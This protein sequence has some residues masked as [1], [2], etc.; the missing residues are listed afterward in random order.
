MKKNAY[1]I[2]ITIATLLSVMSAQC[3]KAE[4]FEIKGFHIDLRVEVMTMPALKAFATQLHE[5]GVNTI[6]MEYE[7]TYPYEKHFTI[8]SKYAYT[9]DEIRDF[10]KHCTTLGIDVIPLQQTF[11]HT[12]YILRHPR[13]SSLAEKISDP[14]QICPLKTER[15]IE[16]FDEL[17]ADMISLH[18]SRYFHIG[19]DETRLLGACPNCAEKVAK[20]GKSKLFAD[21]MKEICNTVIRHGKIPI[22]WAD[23]ILEHPEYISELPKETIFVDWNYGWSNR[24]FG[25]AEALVK[26]GVKFWGAPAIRSHPDNMHITSWEKHF[27]NQKIFIPYC[28]EQKYNGIVMTSWSTSG[29]SSPIW[30][31][32]HEVIDM[33]PLRYVYPM[34]GFN[35]LIYM[36]GKALNQPEPIDPRAVIAEYA[37]EQLG[38]SAEEGKTLYEILTIPQVRFPQAKPRADHF[39]NTKSYDKLIEEMEISVAK[40]NEMKPSRNKTDLEH[41]IL[42][43]NIRLNYI[44][45]KQVEAEINRSEIAKSD[46]KETLTQLEKIIKTEKR[47]CKKF[48]SLQRGY[49]H[50]S[51][52]EEINRYRTAKVIDTYDRLTKAIS[53]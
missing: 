48:A 19:G 51:E 15:C 8:S 17:F 47:L 42:M 23:I 18:T 38:L 30:E 50:P 28:R 4:N 33:I 45:F 5:I 31:L 41:L 3:V 21:Y 37:C 10:V 7:A 52:I 26:Q 53:R 14:T 39:G 35:L 29:I 11:G 24:K 9:R 46:L 32:D 43:F 12:D 27:D 25:D 22:M 36:Y 16:L 6:L 13:Y 40:L 49:L 34:N 2:L 1:S 20:Q 44:K